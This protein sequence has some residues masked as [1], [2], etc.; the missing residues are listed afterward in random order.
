M[1][2]AVSSRSTVNWLE[3]VDLAHFQISYSKTQDEGAVTVWACSSPGGG[4]MAGSERVQSQMTQMPFKLLLGQ[5]LW[6]M[7]SHCMGQTSHLAIVYEVVSVLCL[8]GT[9]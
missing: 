3:L 1:R 7:Y 4:L 9:M 8:Q 5:V 6:H 2:A